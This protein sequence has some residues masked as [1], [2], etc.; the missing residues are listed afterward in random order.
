MR[1]IGFLK[2]LPVRRQ[3]AL[4]V[5]AKLHSKI[6]GILEGYALARPSVRFSL[7]V[8]KANNDKANWTYAPK[9]GASVMDAAMKVLG[10]L[11]VA[12]CQWHVWSPVESPN[13][14]RP[15]TSATDEPEPD[16]TCFSIEALLPRPECGK[17][18][19]KNF[20]HYRQ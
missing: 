1:V 2:N 18:S 20:Q 7:R 10:Q 19:N 11:A 14:E 17:L 5:S 6:K 4:K 16:S 8:L 15:A 9:V 13:Q 12:Q 3:T